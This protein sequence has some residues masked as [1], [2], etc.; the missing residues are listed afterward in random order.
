[1]RSREQAALEHAKD[2]IMMGAE[3]KSAV[4]TESSRRLTAYHEGGHA[5][6]AL[7]TAGAHPI[8]KATIGPRTML[9]PPPLP[10]LSRPLCGVCQRIYPH[11]L[12][13]Y[14]M[15]AGDAGV[16]LCLLHFMSSWNSQPRLPDDPALCCCAPSLV[17]R[18][19]SDG[20]DTMRVG[21]DLGS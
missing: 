8:H 20:A 11:V 3:R 5:L 12:P 16:L 14:P 2:R 9:P 19:P 15:H 17:E 4:I 13:A 21:P 6:V 1:M 7:L 18:Q 10:S